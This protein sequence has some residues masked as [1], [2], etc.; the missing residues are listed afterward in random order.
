[1]LQPLLSVV[2]LPS[3][4]LW[5]VRGPLVLVPLVV[6]VLALPSLLLLVSL[7]KQLLLLPQLH[8]TRHR[9]LSCC[10]LRRGSDVTYL[11]PRLR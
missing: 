8:S 11:R 5:Y 6:L 3:W 7:A 2:Q 1:M 10:L 9:C 4:R